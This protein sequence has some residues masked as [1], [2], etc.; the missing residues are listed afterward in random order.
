[1]TGVEEAALAFTI[2]QAGIGAVAQGDIAYTG[3]TSDVGV[4]ASQ[5]PDNIRN[6]LQAQTHSQEIA[7]YHSDALAGEAVSVKLVCY[8]QYNGPE[9]QAT[10]TFPSDG[11]RS[12]WG[13]DTKVTVGN[14]LSLDRLP[15][16][17]SWRQI[18]I[19]QYPVVRVPVSIFVDEPWP[20]DNYKLTFMLVLSGMYGFGASPGASIY[21]DW[22]ET[23]D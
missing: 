17:D 2:L 4:I 23:N 21:E 8:V 16:P 18:G 6:A 5:L 3:P 1:V 14:P 11:M 13:A 12:R 10:F 7:S 20:T 15:A 19:A 22:S 9:V